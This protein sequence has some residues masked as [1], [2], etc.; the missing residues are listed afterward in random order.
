MPLA[1]APSLQHVEASDLGI[2]RVRRGRGF[3]YHGPNGGTVRDSETLDRIRV[4]AIP[5]AWS[6]V[7]IAERGDAHLQATGTDSRGRRQYRYHP[8]WRAF[9]DRVKFNRLSVFGEVLPDI[10]AR[11]GADLRL[12]GLPRDKVLAT[13]V[14]L[15]ELTLIRVGNEEYARDN[16]AYG[17]TT[18]R[19][20]H[21]N[22]DGE[23]IRFVFTGKSGQR[24]DVVAQDPRVARVLRRCQEIPGQL[25]FQYLDEDDTPAPVHSHDVNAYL[26]AAGGADVTA[27][28]FR[29]WVATV[30]AASGLA[31]LPIP[32]SDA[33]QRHLV[34]QVVVTVAQELGNT[35]AVCRSSYIHPIVF[36]S[37]PTGALEEQ[38][39]VTPRRRRNL[40]IDE[41]HT[42]SLLRTKRRRSRAREQRRAA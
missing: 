34:N 36:E 21:V 10:R 22:V 17:L 33:E 27:K 3:S 20:R 7:R 37:Y 1:I 42:L 31:A 24:H 41:R 13:V 35:P 14:Q 6:S 29:T 26:R 15:L 8:D 23:E 9:R 25:L 40:T 4:L 5:P 32:S 30:V 16:G 18:L 2:R 12:S 11:V 39:S 38:W 28:D 19:N